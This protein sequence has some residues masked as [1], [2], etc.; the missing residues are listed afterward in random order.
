M[1]SSV[2]GRL[3]AAATALAVIGT[4][5]FAAAPA[6]AA[7]PEITVANTAFTEGSWGDGVD[8]SGSGFAADGS[9]SV[10]VFNGEKSLG[11]DVVTA[12][13]DGAFSTVLLPYLPLT[14]PDDEDDV[15]VTATDGTNDAAPVIL[16][17]LRKAGIQ[18]DGSAITVADLADSEA[19]LG[20]IAGGFVPGEKVTVAVTLNGEAISMGTDPKADR[21]GS[22]VGRL[23][24][25]SGAAPGSLVI[26][27]TG[28]AGHVESTTIKVIGDESNVP[29]TPEVPP[30]VD[31]TPEIPGAPTTPSIKLPVVSG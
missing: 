2:R 29:G 12:D 4:G 18:T 19:G 15:V 17:V 25:S 5:V 21:S 26:T 14:L 22:V 3:G 7:G 16:T 28:E 24:M 9:V 6:N 11:A 31:I 8:I 20:V 10:E 27:L 23:W 30:V 1:L 13:A